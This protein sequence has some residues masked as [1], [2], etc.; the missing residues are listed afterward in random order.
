[1][2]D[3]NLRMS[4]DEVNLVLEGLGSL[5]FVRVYELIAKV[6]QQARDQ[7][8][9]G[10]LPRTAPLDEPEAPTVDE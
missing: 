9:H 1:M 10:A 6:R 4:V 3:I 8:D 5:P 7:L 2:E